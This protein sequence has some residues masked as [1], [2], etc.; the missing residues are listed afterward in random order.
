MFIRDYDDQQLCCMEENM[1]LIVRKSS[2]KGDTYVPSSKSHTIR[3]ILLAAMAEG[4]SHLTNPLPSLDCQSALHAAACF[5]AE[6]KI[7]NGL[8]TVTGVGRKL[9]IPENYIDCGNS[10]TTTYFVA[11]MAALTNGYTVLTG[12]SQI[13]RR[14]ISPV[15]NAVRQLGG[16]A[17]TTRPN[18]DA[19]PVVIKGRMRG[20]TVKFSRS[21]SQFVSSIMLSAPLLDG[22]T[23][24]IN[25][26]PLEKPYLQL[27]IDW[28]KRYGVELEEKREDYT[29]FKIKGNQT[30]KAA[31]TIIPADWSA[32]AFPLVAG[33][34]TSSQITIS[35]VDFKDSQGDKAVVDHL[36][37][38]GADIVKDQENNRIIIAGGKPL[39]SSLTIDLTDIP[40][41]LPALAVAAAFA[42]G[43]TKFTGLA[44]V[45]LKET[46]RVAVMTNELKKV[47]AEVHAGDDYM[48]VRGGRPLKGT[49]VESYDD[50]RIAMAMAICGLFAEG[51]MRVKD[52]ECAAVSF[53]DFVKVMQK[54]GSDMR[55]E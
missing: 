23:E 40:D 6:T 8:W 34:V 12:D 2:L 49:V 14:P 33:V 5:G 47:G 42:E 54:L 45:R 13:R 11:S 7:E 20:G 32:V 30:Y 1:E 22:D 15:L 18:V 44:H 28:M 29:Y 36:I 4:T 35:G 25:E 31:D 9:Q 37:A 24:I 52:S 16:T 3:A 55:E 19:C 51:E 46:D 26:S 21:I 43:E 41:S 10:G 39:R 38:M 48:I 53:P 17:F 27:S 50:H